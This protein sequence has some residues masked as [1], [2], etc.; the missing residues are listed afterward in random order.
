MRDPSVPPASTSALQV[1]ALV[2]HFRVV[3]AIG[4]GGMGEVYLARDLRLGR[5]VAIK[6]I[7]PAALGGRT[8]VDRFL[9]EARATARFNHPNIVTIYAVGE[10]EDRPYV[11]LEF[12]DGET[13][14]SRLRGGPL[15]WMEAVRLGL[16]IC[17]AVAEAHANAV[18]HRDLKPENVII[19]RDGRPRVVDFGLARVVSQELEVRASGARGT[20][21]DEGE[22]GAVEFDAS[23]TRTAPAEGEST[24]CGTPLYMS[25]E[26]WRGEPA[27]MASDVW[28][29]G[30]MLYEML[31]GRHPWGDLR[32]FQ[33]SAKVLSSS[34]VEPPRASIPRELEELLVRCLSKRPEE[35]PSAAAL[36]ESLRGQLHAE[37][38]SDKLERGPFRGLLAFDDRHAEL[39]FGREAETDAFVERLRDEA[40]LAVVAHSG[41]GKSSFV[42]AGVIPRLREL[43][44]TLVLRL[45]P[46]AEP[47]RALA[48]RIASG[49][50]A[51]SLQANATTPASDP[52][53]R[54]TMPEALVRKEV[55]SEAIEQDLRASPERSAVYLSDLAERR[56]GM[57]LLFVDQ[58][59]EVF[60]LG[61]SEQEGKAFLR[62]LASAADDGAGSVRVCFTLRDDFVGRVA[63]SGVARQLLAGLFVLQTPTGERLRD[64][65]QRALSAVGYAWESPELLQE[66]TE[67]VQ[68]ESAALPLLQFAGQMMWDRRDRASKR[69]TR[70]AYEQVGGV[71]GALARHADAVLLG[72]SPAQTSLA[73][74]LLLRLVTPQNTRRVM[75][76]DALLSGL[77]AQANEVLQMLV[78][79]RLVIARGRTGT[80]EEG[81]VEIAHEAMIAAWGR[82]ARWLEEA[83]DELGVLVQA[84]QAA[85]LWD[86]RGRRDEEVWQGDA[87][88]DA[89][90]R[91]RRTTRELP[92]VVREFLDA[93]RK[94]ELRTQRRRRAAL[95]VTVSALAGVALVLALQNRVSQKRRDEAEAA[96]EVAQTRRAEALYEGA[97]AAL[98]RLDPL[99]ARARLRSSL[100]LRDMRLARPLW[101]KLKRTPMRWSTQVTSATNTVA[102]SPDGSEVA[103]GGNDGT[104]FRVDPV[105]RSQQ[106]LRG[107]T[108]QITSV[109]FGAPDTLWVRT[110]N[111]QLSAWNLEDHRLRAVT[112]PE[113]SSPVSVVDPGGKWAAMLFE[114]GTVRLI[115]PT[116]GGGMRTWRAHEGRASAASTDPAGRLLAVG[117]ESGRVRVFEVPSG[118]QVSETG[119]H[120]GRVRLTHVVPDTHRMQAFLSDKTLRT[121]DLDTGRE[122]ASLP[123]AIPG[124]SYVAFESSG[125]LIAYG[126]AD[127]SIRVVEVSTGQEKAVLRGQADQP[128]RIAFDRT[129]RVLA[130]SSMGKDVVLW[131]LDRRA[132]ASP[133]PR[134]HS[135]EV[136]GL[137]V[138]PDGSRVVSGGT[139]Q[140]IRCWDT[141]TGELRW[142]A[143]GQAARVNA[144]SFRP[145]GKAVAS[146]AMDGVVRI[147]DAATGAAMQAWEGG[148]PLMSVSWSGDGRKLVSV[149]LT[150][151][152][153]VWAVETGRLES[154]IAVQGRR[155]WA[156]ELHSDGRTMAL[157]LVDGGIR[158]VDVVSGKELRELSGHRGAVWSVQWAGGGKLYSASEDG[159]VMVWEGG[160]A[161]GRLVHEHAG[162]AAFVAVQGSGER[163]GVFGAG[164]YA[165]VLE[166]GSGRSLMLTGHRVRDVNIGVFLPDGERIATAADD[167]T[168]RLWRLADGEPLWRGALLYP[169][170]PLLLS[171]RGWVDPADGKTRGRPEGAWVS[172]VEK[173]CRLADIPPD[174]SRLCFAPDLGRIESWDLSAGS[175]GE[176]ASVGAPLR[177]VV[178][179]GSGCVALTS[180]GR[181]VELGR[182]KG[183]TTLAESVDAIARS[184]RGVLIASQR[185]VRELDAGGRWTTLFATD[186]GVTAV[187]DLGEWIGVGYREGGLE[188]VARDG[189]RRRAA[190]ELVPTSAVER[191]VAG[192]SGALIAGYA[193][194]DVG[195]WDTES[196]SQLMRFGLHGPAVHLMMDGKRLVAA[197]ELGDSTVVDLREYDL[198]YCSLLAEVWEG[199]PVVWEGGQA[200]KRARPAGH[201][202]AGR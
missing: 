45:R 66:M 197:T 59:E 34:P 163:V 165:T 47:L 32:V 124:L 182:G 152:V 7:R 89:L 136:H 146:A 151:A 83:R 110:W 117:A 201:V 82:L 180:E 168:V 131:D 171:H 121:F 42:Q 51:S 185:E 74:T 107:I 178:A 10:I 147:W 64:I 92:P 140:A 57:V 18:V 199:V 142:V 103:I 58:L 189:G 172:A 68:G 138:S 109:D 73:R 116:S 106:V 12:V 33:I 108:G 148:G 11:A 183:S 36:C 114:D 86:R 115:D 94:R 162:R 150:G 173:G 76:R 129:G 190:F 56:G 175:K 38:R 49:E 202:C 99:E 98:E 160:K 70:E 13:L 153:R 1:G 93:G 87:L 43:H 78:E 102:M 156:G 41:A 63:D 95:A 154:E 69:L 79:G 26:Q 119:E 25:P 31:D 193:T 72:M 96:S 60:T 30:L 28:S 195:I 29:I 44:R 127:H 19:G 81:Q 37:R 135:S 97:R 164:G 90:R 144:V 48:A 50:S 139:D 91:A 200:V 184:S 8:A 104:V 143:R 196:G 20:G 6:V 188:V 39:F 75:E 113:P 35:R 132:G 157:G 27:S 54:A 17:E 80:A 88:G 112:G 174:A 5:K 101:W 120:A 100:E 169:K 15:S 84:E 141:E 198:D 85:E 176:S 192:P 137:A 159:K 123:L 24:I 126:S 65:L 40:I 2:D 9:S 149:H 179:G 125:T 52:S 128:Y 130:S 71:A 55:P 53:A 145:D 166:P 167:G 122:L 21:A 191:I 22:G 194:G 187:A 134:G 105:D 61:A 186:I 161:P 118:R 4:Q 177:A 67:A 181:A 158:I 155:P 46:G 133:E 170:G 16:A 77:D 14:A 23:V 111:G 3:R 62:A